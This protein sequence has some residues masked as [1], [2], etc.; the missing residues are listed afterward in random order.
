LA[1]ARAAGR[2][3]DERM[4]LSSREAEGSAAKRGLIG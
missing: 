1:S 3:F 4:E 2:D